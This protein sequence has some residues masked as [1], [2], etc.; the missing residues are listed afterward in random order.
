MLAE[1]IVMYVLWQPIDQV[2]EPLSKLKTKKE[3]VKV[4][5]SFRFP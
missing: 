5:K 1:N 3:K 2:N 4:L